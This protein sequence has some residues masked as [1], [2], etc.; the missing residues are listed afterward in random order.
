[1]LA[2]KGS[3]MTFF[4]VVSNG[5]TVARVAGSTQQVSVGTTDTGRS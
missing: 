4:S 2:A 1:M 5:A 3:F